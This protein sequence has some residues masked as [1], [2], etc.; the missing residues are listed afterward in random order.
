MAF[1][2]VT[3]NGNGERFVAYWPK[4]ASERKVGDSIVGKYIG[5]RE[6]KSPNGMQILYALETDDG[7]VGVNSSAALA[8]TMAT[9]P[10]GSYIKIVFN[11]KQT[12]KNGRQFNS[13]SVFIDDGEGDSKDDGNIDLD[14]L[15]F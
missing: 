5:N 8:R 2:E 4:R 1:K 13:F 7:L 14:D 11:G 15:G 3:T 6:M 12:S 9:V 10:E